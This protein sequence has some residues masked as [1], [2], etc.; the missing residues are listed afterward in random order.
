MYQLDHFN[1]DAFHYSR[2]E[3]GRD[4]PSL[5][6]YVERRPLGCKKNVRIVQVEIAN[7]RATDNSGHFVSVRW[8]GPGW[9]P[10]QQRTLSVTGD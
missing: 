9:D 1:E 5:S 4:V 10:A 6:L 2:D 3:D 8:R 7:Q